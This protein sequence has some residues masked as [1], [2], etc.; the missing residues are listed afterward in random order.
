MTFDG[1][2]NPMW[3]PKGDRLFFLRAGGGASRDLLAMDVTMTA[4]TVVSRPAIVLPIKGF[5]I[6]GPPPYDTIDGNRFVVL[7]P[8]AAATPPGTEPIVVTLNWFEEL[9]RLVPVE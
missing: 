8:S 1:A 4:D 2:D 7:R 3:S 9:K 5:A 6:T